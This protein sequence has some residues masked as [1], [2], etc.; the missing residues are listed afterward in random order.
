MQIKKETIV[1]AYVK[2]DDS[3]KEMLRTM[4][5]NIE[6]E[7]AKVDKNRPVTERIKTLED[8]C[9]ELGDEH[10]FVMIWQPLSQ[11]REDLISNTAIVDV[12]VYLKLRIITAALNEGW[13][14][15]F[16]VDEWRWYPW[17]RLWTE[18]ELADKNDKWKQNHALI[19]TGGY[20]TEYAAFTFASSGNAPLYAIANVGSRL[21]YKSEALADYS[22]RQFADLWADFH[23]IRKDEQ[24]K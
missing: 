9:R 19:K 20:D 16:T 21:C 7:T 10:P 15:K 23:L 11:Y 13:Q 22:G 6:F 12:I 3:V 18:E 8:A 14:P 4:F 17:H 1:N 24:Q 5:P 2:G